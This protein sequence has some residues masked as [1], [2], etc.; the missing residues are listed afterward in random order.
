[1][2]NVFSQILTQPSES[3]SVEEFEQFKFPLETD[4][5]YHHYHHKML[6]C[7]K[8]SNITRVFAMCLTHKSNC[9]LILPSNVTPYSSL[10]L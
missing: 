1:M 5:K 4:L 2:I 6:H 7:S 9:L 3:M 10:N 8:Y